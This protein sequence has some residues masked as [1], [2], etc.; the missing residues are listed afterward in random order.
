MDDVGFVSCSTLYKEQEQAPQPVASSSKQAKLGAYFGAAEESK[1]EVQKRRYASVTTKDCYRTLTKGYRGKQKEVIETAILGADV[2]VVAPTGM[3][4]SLCFQIPAAAE[5]H[6]VTLVISPLLSLMKNQVSKLQELNVPATAYTSD[7]L[8]SEKRKILTELQTGRPTTRLLY[9]TPEMLFTAEFNKLIARLHQR[10]EV[11]RLVV[12]EAHCISEWGHDFRSEYRKLGSFRDKYPDVPLMALTASATASVQEDIVNSLQMN[13]DQMLKVTHPFNRENLFYEVQYS[14]S[15]S[16]SAQMADVHRFIALLHQRRGRPSSGIVYCR[17]RATCDELSHY[18]RSNGI[19]AR[20]YHRGLKSKEL[21][22]TLQEWQDGG[23]GCGGVDVVCATIAFGMGIDKPDVRYIV[24]FDLPKSLEGYYQETGRAGRDGEPAKCV[25]Y[26]S[27]ENAITVKQLV[28]RS[29][30]ARKEHALAMSLFGEPEP[31]QRSVDSFSSLVN[32][33]ENVSLCRHISICKYFG[34]TIDENDVDVRKSYCNNMCDVCKYPDKVK[35]RKESLSSEDW[36]LPH[37][38]Q[39]QK[40]AT[41][42]AEEGEGREDVGLD[43][44]EEA[45]D[46]GIWGDAE[47]PEDE[48]G[49]PKICGGAQMPVSD[50]ADTKQGINSDD[51]VV[52]ITGK[53]SKIV[54]QGPSTL[55]RTLSPTSVSGMN[56]PKRSRVD[57]SKPSYS[58][59][60]S[61]TLRKPFKTPFKVPFKKTPQNGIDIAPQSMSVPTADSSAT[62]TSVAKAPP[63]PSSSSRIGK[64]GSSVS[65]GPENLKG[66]EVANELIE[67]QSG[68]DGARETMKQSPLTSGYISIMEGAERELSDEGEIADMDEREAR[69]SSPEIHSDENNL[70]LDAAFS[71]KIS[72]TLREQS[73]SKIKS[74]LHKVFIKDDRS[75]ELWKKAGV[76]T[77]WQDERGELLAVVAREIEFSLFLMSVSDSGYKERAGWKIAAIDAL[78]NDDVWEH[79]T[80]SGTCTVSEDV[81]EV[82]LLVQRVVKD[83]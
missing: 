65:S 57:Y 20:P 63:L 80:G 3:G 28:K 73:I 22:K 2:F 77:P 34:E 64:S 61:N 1:F 21:E 69:S 81:R 5:K 52:S 4:K 62:R 59:G 60:M 67:T 45:D 70:E 26:Y 41:T 18:L 35:R 50:P 31:S 33:A 7:T 53:T 71:Q 19:S 13:R 55:K 24:H 38:E 79:G 66:K 23:D 43:D 15:P 75:M 25:L 72:K 29:R 10:G 16:P 51:I 30:N 8:A 54:I 58:S 46:G 40:R 74:A 49:Y 6:G 27:R 78:F 56:V 17:M 11:N 82:A 76:R 68:A 48:N 36:V 9:I 12:D 42:G 14:A 37:I 83:K 47:E 39:L 44:T 32:L